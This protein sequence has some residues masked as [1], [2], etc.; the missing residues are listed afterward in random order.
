MTWNEV[1]EV[2]LAS[3]LDAPLDFVRVVRDRFWDLV[4]D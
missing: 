4:G 3:Q 1:Y 2:I